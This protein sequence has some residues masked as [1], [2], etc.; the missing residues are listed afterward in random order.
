MAEYLLALIAMLVGMLALGTGGATTR[1][2]YTMRWS[3][4]LLGAFS[5]IVSLVQFYRI[6]GFPLLAFVGSGLIV[7]MGAAVVGWYFVSMVASLDDRRRSAEPPPAPDFSFLSEQEI[8]DNDKAATPSVRLS[9]TRR[10]LGST[11]ADRIAGMRFLTGW[12][13]MRR[14]P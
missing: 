13:F 9:L 6:G 1:R 11:A 4:V 10:I 14:G 7:L 3:L 5:T 2:H 8:N 12:S